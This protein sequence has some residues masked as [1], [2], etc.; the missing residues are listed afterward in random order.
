MG[1]FPDFAGEPQIVGGDRASGSAEGG[2]I[3]K[4]VVAGR[5]PAFL[6]DFQ[7]NRTLLLNDTIGESV[8]RDPVGGPRGSSKG[9]LAL[10]LIE[11]RVDVVVLGDP[12]QRGNRIA[13]VDGQQGVKAAVRGVDDR[14][15]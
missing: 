11:N 14:W 2:G 13:N 10:D 1:G 15:S 8:H 12:P 3:G 4:R 9:H 6:G 5:L 7:S